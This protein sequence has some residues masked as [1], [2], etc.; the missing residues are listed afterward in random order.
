[1]NILVIKNK[2]FNEDDIIEILP[3]LGHSVYPYSPPGDLSEHVN[4]DITQDLNKAIIANSIDVIFS[5]N[6]YPIISY[7]IK[8]TPVKYIS[9]VYDSPHIALYTCSIIFPNNFIFIFDYA[10]YNELKSGGI[11]TV[12][13]LPLSVNSDRL[14]AAAS[15][16]FASNFDVSFVGSLYNDKHNFYE[17]L[18]DKLIDNESYTKG[19]ID[20]IIQMQSKVYGKFFIPELLNGKVLQEIRNAYPYNT[21]SDSIATD[22]YVYAHY[23]FARKITSIERINLLCRISDDYDLALFSNTDSSIITKSHSIGPIDYY[24]QMPQVFANSKINLNI[25]LK[26]IQTGIPLR[27]IDIMGCGGFLLTN[28]QADFARHFDEGVD[29]V[30]FEDEKDLMNKIEYFLFHE[31]ERMTIAKNG[32]NKIIANHQLID[33][34]EYM[35]GI[36]IS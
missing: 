32:Q 17:R 22:E 16:P 8:D 14:C 18:M 24:T 36:A 10:T 2:T 25:T 15:I 35:L 30:Y 9:Y 21:Q 20:S 31:D 28:Y 29:Y 11:S 23:F 1:M 26:S 7:T 19:Y 13:Y 27:C 4:K 33:Y 3:K 5:F 6:Y 12:Y 34:L